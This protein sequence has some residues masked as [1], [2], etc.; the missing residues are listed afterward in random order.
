MQKITNSIEPMTKPDFESIDSQHSDLYKLNA[1]YWL[2]TAAGYHVYEIS[3]DGKLYLDMVTSRGLRPV[4]TLKSDV[5]F[6]PTENKI[7]N[8]PVWNIYGM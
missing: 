7:N 5:L 8:V 2:A 3:V 6:V 4:I 1:S